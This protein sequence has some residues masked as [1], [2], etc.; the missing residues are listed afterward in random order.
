MKILFLVHRYPPSTGGTQTLAYNLAT[1]FKKK[2]HSVMVYTSTHPDRP[3]FEV[4]DGISIRRF[5]LRS[6]LLA[7]FLKHP[8]YITPKMIPYL[9][10]SDLN[11]VDLIHGFG[12]CTFQ[13]LLTILTRKLRK[14]PCILT[15]QYHPWG[16]IYANTAGIK[17]INSANKIIAQCKSEFTALSQ[18]VK[19]SKI[20]IIPTGINSSQF[21]HLPE[22]NL[23][24]HFDIQDEKV[25]LSVGK[26]A[27]HKGTDI[28][29]KAIS[30]LNQRF[31]TRIKLLLVG[32]GQREA[33]YEALV[34]RLGIQKAVLFMGRVDST[35][36]LEA[37]A[38]ADVFVFPSLHE[39]FGI[40]LIEAAACGKPI[41]STRVGVASDII[42][43]SKTGFFCK[44]S[45]PHDL[46]RKILRVIG[47]DSIT[48]NAKKYRKS[49][50]VKFDWSNVITKMEETYL[51]IL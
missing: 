7:R 30:L 20:Q 27:G 13:S 46:A 21:L 40:A 32:T 11:N 15:P 19:K 42:K 10:S 3:V 49:V 17:V 38:S 5:T 29:I 26:L 18:F 16:T 50:L 33:A 8:R 37:Y 23:K 51:E 22:N 36:L 34:N 12:Y 1:M 6:S 9:F 43:E 25:I 48:E 44:Y 28:L 31:K 39:S 45:D 47:N 35:T 41:V 4:K 24:E 2:G 14:I